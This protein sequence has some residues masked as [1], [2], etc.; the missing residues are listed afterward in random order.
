[1]VRQHWDQY[2][3]LPAVAAPLSESVSNI[4]LFFYTAQA[5]F[6]QIMVG[7]KQ[8]D[9]PEVLDMHSRKFTTLMNLLMGMTLFSS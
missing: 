5:K 3:V 8:Q 4:S 6:I 7:W 2:F 9:L 1:M